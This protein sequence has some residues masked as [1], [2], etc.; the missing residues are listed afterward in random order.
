MHAGFSE[1]SVTCG[2]DYC[3]RGNCRRKIGDVE[4]DEAVVVIISGDNALAEGNFVHAGGVRDVF[5]G[6]VAL[7]AESWLG[8]FSLPTNKSRKPSLSM[9]A[10]RVCVRVAG[11]ASPLRA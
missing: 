6:A 3:D 7:V 2:R 9:S 4:V 11:S 5:K 8:P 10:R 1:T